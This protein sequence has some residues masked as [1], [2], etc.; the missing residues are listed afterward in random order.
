MEAPIGDGFTGIAVA[1]VA[2]VNPL[3]VIPAA[4]LFAV[5][6]GPVDG[7]VVAGYAPDIVLI[8][9]G[10]I[11]YFVAITSLFMYLRPIKMVQD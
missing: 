4:F 7:L 1:L 10:V 6:N 11:T 3:G 2:M 5:L 8:F 9:S